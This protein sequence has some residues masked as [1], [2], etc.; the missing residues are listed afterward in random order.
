MLVV[1]LARSRSVADFG[2]DAFDG[3]ALRRHALGKRVWETP[4]PKLWPPPLTYA[5]VR[6]ASVE[7]LPDARFR[8]VPYFRYALTWTRPPA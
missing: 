5:Q 3:I 6:Q 2:R 1:G 4:A 8:R 7:I